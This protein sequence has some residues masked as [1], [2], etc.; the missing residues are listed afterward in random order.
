MTE[1]FEQ[2]D[3]GVILDLDAIEA[4]TNELIPASIYEGAI[5]ELEYKLSAS[6]QQP[7]W[8]YVA[9]IT[10][11]EFT[12]RKLYGNMSFSPK[13]LPLTKATLQR[14]APELVTNSF[15]PKAIADNGDLVGLPVRIKTKIGK[16]QDGDS[17]TEIKELLAAATQGDS[18][19]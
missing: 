19:I 7:M 4:A 14:I 13:A 11:G 9:T 8:S 10:D 12:G 6:S 1:Y 18:F 2:G 16:N 5:E 15:N 17:R 3:E